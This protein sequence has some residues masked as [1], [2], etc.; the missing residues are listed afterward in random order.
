M[1]EFKITVAERQ[2]LPRLREIEKAG[3]LD[4]YVNESL[5]IT[6][7]LLLEQ[8]QGTGHRNFMAIAMAWTRPTHR[9]LVARIG[10]HIAGYG[11][12]RKLKNISGGLRAEIMHLYVDTPNRG[13][14][15]GKAFLDSCLAWTGSMAEIVVNVVS[16]NQAAIRFY[17][18]HG[19][20]PSGNSPVSRLAILSSGVVIPEIEM[21]RR[22]SEILEH[23][24]IKD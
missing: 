9:F 23:L 24:E 5:K 10:N 3:W 7:A 22:P 18:L 19:F 4:A 15:I 1:Q 14:G 17:E 12:F 20:K 8:L 11:I 16:Y 2:D 6:S 21:L 13:Q